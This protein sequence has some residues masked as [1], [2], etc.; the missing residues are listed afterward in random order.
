MKSTK[1]ERFL[2]WNQHTQRK[3]KSL[4]FNFQCQRLS[5]SFSIFFW[6]K[7]INLAHFLL[8]TLITSILKSL[9]FLKW[10]PNFDTCPL[11]QFSKF[12]NFLW[13]C[14]FIGKNLSDSVPPV[15]KLHNPYCHNV[16]LPSCWSP[17]TM[18]F[19]SQCRL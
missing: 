8:L 15:W 16:H 13:V 2:T 6:L 7:N 1:L 3:C 18:L 4:T 14:W 10:C 12:N 11:T 19:T 17:H 5:E 9:Y